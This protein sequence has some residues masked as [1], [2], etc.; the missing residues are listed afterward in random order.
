GT[1]TNSSD[2]I[3][4]ST[5]IQIP[6]NQTSATLTI[7]PN[8]DNRTEGTETVILTIVATGDPNNDYTIGAANADTVTI[9]DNVATVTMSASD[10]SASEVG[11]DAGEFT[12][13]RSGGDTTQALTVTYSI[14]GT[15]GNGSD[16]VGIGATIVI[17]GNQ[18]ST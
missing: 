13:T 12:F 11:L 6:A 7:T 17:S 4:I 8:G 18:L 14:G 15:A 5:I 3:G 1:A 16:Y 9:A 10:G 2:Y